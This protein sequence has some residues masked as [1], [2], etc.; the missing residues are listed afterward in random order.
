MRRTSGDAQSS[1]MRALPAS[2]VLMRFLYQAPV[3]DESVHPWPE[4]L[5][6]ELWPPG[7]FGVEGEP[8][9]QGKALT[10]GGVSQ[11]A[12]HRPGPFRIDVV[13]R[14]G[15][16]AAPVVEA[17]REQARVDVRRQV[18]RSL[19]VHV[20]TEHEARHGDGAQEVL[21]RRFR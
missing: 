5:G 16:D 13:E 17:R 20:G 8:F 6:Q 19:D 10:R 12:N 11:I 21:Q 2:P 1:P 15:R 14:E 3:V 7:V 4:R 9:P 18:W